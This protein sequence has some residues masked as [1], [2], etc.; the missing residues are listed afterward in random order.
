MVRCC[1]QSVD[2]WLSVRL[3][4]LGAIIAGAASLLALLSVRS[5]SLHPAFAAFSVSLATGLTSILSYGVRVFVAVVG[6]I[7]WRLQQAHDSPSS[8]VMVHQVRTVAELENSMNSV[9]RVLFYSQETPQEAALVVPSSVP[10]N[11]PKEPSVKF[12]KVPCT[13]NISALCWR[14]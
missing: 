4:T 14:S 6:G 3:E 8:P 10:A 5:G 1:V 12:D 11:W 13:R 2:R 9:E 7:A